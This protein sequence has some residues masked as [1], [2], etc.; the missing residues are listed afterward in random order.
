MAGRGCQMWGSGVWTRWLRFSPILN[1][2]AS[3]SADGFLYILEPLNWKSCP[4]NVALDKGVNATF[5]VLILQHRRERRMRRAVF[6]K[7]HACTTLSCRS[8]HWPECRKCG[9]KEHCPSATSNTFSPLFTAFGKKL[10]FLGLSTFLDKNKAASE[11]RSQHQVESVATYTV[12]GQWVIRAL[13]D[14][15]FKCVF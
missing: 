14:I 7:Q 2:P 6:S 5:N 15:T 11:R 9:V 10:W 12:E 8:F 4:S 1:H 13:C 3:S